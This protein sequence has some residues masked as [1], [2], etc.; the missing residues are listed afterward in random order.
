MALVYPVV[1]TLSLVMSSHVFMLSPLFVH[2]FHQQLKGVDNF[3]MFTF[4]D[5]FENPFEKS[6]IG[7][8]DLLTGRLSPFCQID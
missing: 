2:G 3:I 8:I 7:G 1:M 5:C 6:I 4:G